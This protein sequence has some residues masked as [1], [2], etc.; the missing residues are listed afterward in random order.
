MRTA[1]SP[2]T[3]NSVSSSVVT[4]DCTIVGGG[5]AGIMLGLLLARQG[6]QVDVLEKHSD[7]LRDFR[8]DTI[9][10]STL[11]LL[12]ELRLLE[13]FERLPHSTM[14]TARLRWG[15]VELVL[16]DFRLLPTVR[17]HIAFMPQWDLLSLLAESAAEEP[18]FSLRMATA[19]VDLLWE[20]SKVVGVRAEGA[21]GAMVEF[22]SN[23]VVLADGR[24]SRLRD[25]AG[26]AVTGIESQ[27]DVLWFR[28]DRDP[29]E[30]VPLLQV[31][32]GMV[33]TIDRGD[34]YQIAHVVRRG[35]WGGDVAALSR[36]RRR[37]GTLL[38][39][40]SA[41]LDGLRL[42]DIRVLEVRVD[43]PRRWYREGLLVIGDAAHAMSPVAGVGVNLAIQDAVAAARR[44]GHRLSSG[45]PTVR[46]LAAVQ[47]RRRWP[48]VVTQSV[49]RRIERVLVRTTDDGVLPPPPLPLRLLRRVPAL[50]HLMGYFIGLGLRPEQVPDSLRSAPR[51]RAIE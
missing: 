21:D 2:G 50:R 9:H 12:D 37:V 49:Q 6:V 22:H 41:R 44:L 32:D 45:R 40:L 46:D 11:Q 39:G 33:I 17:R 29:A 5:P 27:I 47:R 13:K 4:N 19:G 38:P 42:E 43:G 26:L 48:A 31:G 20:E 10:P 24:D 25:A 18:G 34:F 1:S 15:E 23:L 16:A 3:S 7:F 51:R 36:V 28:L 30:R 14:P 8:G 35:E